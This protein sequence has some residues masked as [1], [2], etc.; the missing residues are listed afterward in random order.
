MTKRSLKD[1]IEHIVPLDSVIWCD[2]GAE[3]HEDDPQC[4]ECGEPNPELNSEPIETC[5]SCG[6]D[7][8][9][10]STFGGVYPEMKCPNC[11][12]SVHESNEKEN[13]AP[14][15]DCGGT[16]VLHRGN[17]DAGMSDAGD[18]EC[19]LCNG[20]GEKPKTRQTEAT[21]FDRFMDSILISEGA[22]RRPE[23]AYDSPQRLR[24]SRHQE[25]PLGRIKFGGG[26]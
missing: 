17:M 14:C 22:G 19:A 8:V 5:D 26:Q 21:G 10:V 6:S 7:L 20:S 2:C 1:L 12:P 18:S 15:S 11:N 16:G 3:M 25:R 9:S 23:K 4:P 13:I 24:A